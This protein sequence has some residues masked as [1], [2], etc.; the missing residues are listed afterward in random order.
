MRVSLFQPPAAPPKPAA[1]PAPPRPPVNIGGKSPDDIRQ[2][3]RMAVMQGDLEKLQL[4]VQMA[5]SIGLTDAA[6]HGRKKLA[7]LLG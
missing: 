3:L 2:D 4:A 7:Q 6:S 5:D 1:P